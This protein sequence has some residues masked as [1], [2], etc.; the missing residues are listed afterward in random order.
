MELYVPQDTGCTY[1]TDDPSNQQRDTNKLSIS[2]EIL[3]AT[4][5]PKRSPITA[6]PSKLKEAWEWDY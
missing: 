4:R 1:R 2:A 5:N 3:T 6:L